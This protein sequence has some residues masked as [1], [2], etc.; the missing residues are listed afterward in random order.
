MQLLPEIIFEDQ[1]LIVVYKPSGYLSEK[2]KGNQPNIEDWTNEYL[3]GKKSNN[4]VS[5]VHRLDKPVAGLLLLAKRK[6]ILKILNKTFEERKITKVYT[7]ILEGNLKAKAGNLINYLIK[8]SESKSA[9][10]AFPH[11]A[12]AQKA[13]LNFK[14]LKHFENYTVVEILL[15]TGRYHQIRAQFSA[16][17][18]PIV[19]DNKYGSTEK[20]ENLIYLYASFLS[21]IHPISNEKV[22]FSASVPDFPLWRAAFTD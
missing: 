10:L 15:K 21:F 11:E 2:D 4:Q 18:H 1:Y 8:D 19:G 5:I 9:K 3:K 20:T 22:E 7:A 12:G 6:D 16:L 14:N 13:E 17:G